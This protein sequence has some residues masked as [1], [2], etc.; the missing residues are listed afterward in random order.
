MTCKEGRGWDGMGMRLNG[1]S[2][3]MVL[4]LCLVS[5]SIVQAAE[6]SSAYQVRVNGTAIP[7]YRANVWEPGYVPSYGGPY[8]FCSFDLTGEATVEVSTVRSLDKLAV[9]PESRGVTARVAEAKATLRI[10]KP[11]QLVFEPDGKNGPLMI[12]SNP[13]EVN[14]PKEDDPNVTYFGPGV[15]DA[16]AIEL[17]DNQTL[18][19]AAGAIVRGGIHARGANIT[20]RGRG[21]LDGNSYPRFEG[22]TR[23]P[24][25][26]DN[27]R[28]VT[29]EGII[30]KDGWSWTFVLQGCDGVRVDNVKLLCCRVENGDGFDIVNSR[31][32]TISRSF[33]RSDDD[34]ISPKGM[35]FAGGQAVENLTVEDCVLWTDRAHVWRFG[36]ECQTQAM[37]NMVFRNLD[38]LHFPDIWTHDEV[39]FCISMEPAEDMPIQ[40][41]LFEDIRIRTAG[42]RGFID[43]RPKFTKWAKK[44]T[45][46]RIENVVFS[47]VSFT[48]PAGKSPGRIRISG[49]DAEH[50]VRN[51]SFQ[52]VSRNGDPVQKDSPGVEVTGS[53]TNVVFGETAKH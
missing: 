4:W 20:I 42:Q 10:Q 25:L 50:A 15:H 8:W 41:V 53:V 39:P 13:P 6:D 22:P 49:P 11:A 44:Q 14:P 23:Y 45:P 2:L 26:L 9:L 52:N 24:L 46:G 17:A 40:N 38:I 1:V 27:C 7:V 34:V 19:L 29:V 5:A 47:N 48:G 28:D 3:V 18:Y 37:R 12:F 21:I 31:D 43:V 16:G 33:V 32:V 35:G 51:V 36:A 30:I